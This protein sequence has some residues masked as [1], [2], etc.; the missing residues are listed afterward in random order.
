MRRDQRTKG[1]LFDLVRRSKRKST[2]LI[3]SS[4]PKLGG[5]CL[6]FGFRGVFFFGKTFFFFY[7]LDLKRTK[8]HTNVLVKCATTFNT[9]KLHQK[10]H[11]ESQSLNNRTMRQPET[12]WKHLSLNHSVKNTS[13]NTCGSTVQLQELWRPDCM[14]SIGGCQVSHLE[15]RPKGR[16]LK[17]FALNCGLDWNIFN[18]FSGIFVV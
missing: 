9:L 1:R 11:A 13:E 5:L 17:V 12:C 16:F 2:D 10:T 3:Q 8:L 14:S 6:V 18:C 4:S 15:N 7:G